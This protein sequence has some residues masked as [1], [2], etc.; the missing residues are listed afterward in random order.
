M[1]D[2][3]L[4]DRFQSIKNTFDN[5]L[6][7]VKNYKLQIIIWNTGKNGKWEL[8]SCIYIKFLEPEK[9]EIYSFFLTLPLYKSYCS[10]LVFLKNYFHSKTLI[11]NVFVK[12]QINLLN[13]CGPTCSSFYFERIYDVLC[14]YLSNNF[15]WILPPKHVCGCCSSSARNWACVYQ[16]QSELCLRYLS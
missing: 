14:I 4:N 11:N 10:M 9:S 3:I 2:Q 5:K 6:R 16:L 7:S 8:T 1:S 12:K 13:N 15:V